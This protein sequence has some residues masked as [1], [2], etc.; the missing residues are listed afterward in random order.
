MES[1]RKL[2][3]SIL[4]VC[5]AF[6][7]AA[8][9][10]TYYVSKSGN[11]GNSC[12]QAQSTAK[13]MLTIN[14]GIRCLTAGDAL[15]V[16]GGTYAESLINNIP[17][18]ISWS[19]KVRVAAY[20]G[21]AVWLAPSSG[22]WVVYF[23]GTPSYIELD[24]IN[25]DGTNI[26]DASVFFDDRT[27]GTPNHIRLQNAEVHHREGIGRTNAAIM[28]GGHDNEFLNLTVH[29]TGGPDGFYVH[30]QQNLI[31]RCNV[32]GVSMAGIQIYHNPAQ[33]YYAPP[34]AN[35]VSNTRIH[36]LTTSTFFGSPDIRV[37][38]IIVYGVNNQLYNN[39]IYNLNFPYTGGNAGIAVAG[40]GTQI[41]N[42]TIANNTTEGISLASGATGSVVVNN[43]A[44]NNT[45]A[46]YTNGGTGTAT[47]TNLFNINPLFVNPSAGN[48]QLQKGSPA[49]DAGTSSS[50]AQIDLAGTARPQGSATDIG[51]FEYSSVSPPPVPPAPQSVK[52]LR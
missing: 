15:L 3:L 38:G 26:G 41:Y 19:K 33:P 31:D 4:V 40:N 9:G 8:F 6:P 17:S 44:Y 50:I 5:A 11:D 39:L 20:P 10:A 47:T 18:G 14:K 34:T 7:G 30:G 43:I 23:D 16:R 12:A 35:I 28:V 21:E 29:G 49:I 46:S 25:I 37:W 24:G 42:N 1:V 22:N 32:Y 13:P 27:G 36:D 48:Y 52:V 51:A 45:G 2:A